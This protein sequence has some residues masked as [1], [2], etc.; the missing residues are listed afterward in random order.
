MGVPYDTL[1]DNAEEAFQVLERAY[2]H[3]KK[4]RS[5]YPM[6]VRKGT[7]GKH[8]FAGKR[9]FIDPEMLHGEDILEHIVEEFPETPIVSTTG[10]ASRELFE[11]R[12]RRGDGHGKDFLTVGSMGHCSSIAA[13]IAL[14]QP[15]REVLCVDG[16]GAA[17]MHMG[18][19]VTAGLSGAK[20]FKH[21]LINNAAHDSVGGQPTG[22]E[23]VDFAGVARACGY[24]SAWT[25]RRADEIP[26]ALRRLRS[27]E[28][29]CLLE[30]Q[31]L[32]G[33]RADLGRPTTS[34]ID[35][36]EAFMSTLAE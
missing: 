5:P 15:Q 25:V 22:A 7:F 31:A 6:I 8:R 32:A 26:E 33:A 16:D 1:P 12:A 30:I 34:T 14:A 27:E 36:K 9:D 17:V 19:F 24:R 3:M 2:A 10:F 23:S 35:N 29:P 18:A 21:I 28:G 4:S 11:I 20:N 13:G